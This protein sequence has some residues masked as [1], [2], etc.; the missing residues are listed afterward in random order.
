ML[1]PLEKDI[2]GADSAITGGCGCVGDDIAGHSARCQQS[3]QI[4]FERSFV[5]CGVDSASMN[6]L[7]A[8]GMKAGHVDNIVLHGNLG[9]DSIEP[10]KID[11]PLYGVEP[12]SKVW[13]QFLSAGADPSLDV[14]RVVE[15]G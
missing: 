8:A 14:L 11:L 9:F 6:D 13:Q 3:L 10:V 7:D 12:I 1:L 15:D 2:D 4:F 5:F